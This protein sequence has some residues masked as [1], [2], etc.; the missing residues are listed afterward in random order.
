MSV[1]FV[2]P[3]RRLR[4]QW[5]LDPGDVRL[6]PRRRAALVLLLVICGY[7]ALA[8]VGVAFQ[9]RSP[10]DAFVSAGIVV[11]LV[12]L[13]VGYLSRP[14]RRPR[15]PWS[16]LALLAQAA[17][18]FLGVLAFGPVWYGF[19]GFLA[20]S[21]LIV[22]PKAVGIPVFALVLAAVVAVSV[23]SAALTDGAGWLVSATY[24]LT[25]NT[26]SALAVFGLSTLARLVIAAHDARAELSR[27][28]VARERLHIARDLHDL[29]GQGLSAIT[30]QC[31]L[32][33][34][35][36]GEHPDRA[37]RVLAD[38]IARARRAASDARTVVGLR[39]D[40]VP[41][42]GASHPGVPGAVAVTVDPVALRLPRI[43]LTVVLL[44]FPVSAAV[45]IASTR[46]LGTAL[47]ALVVG[48]S[49]V[50]LVVR[51]LARPSALHGRAPLWALALLVVLIYAPLP[52]FGLGWHGMPGILGGAVLL[53]LPGLAGLLGLLLVVASTL[54]VEYVDPPPTGSTP[55]SLLYVGIGAVVVSLIVYGLGRV[56]HLVAEVHG[57]RED[58]MRVAVAR[59][60]LRI[61]R[62]VHDLLGLS[63]STVTLKCELASRLL[64]VDPERARLEVADALAAARRALSDVRTVIGGAQRL[65]LE[66][67]CQLAE[68]TLTAADVRVRLR[69]SGAMPDEPVNSVL[70][71]VLREGVTNVLRHSEAERCEIELRSSRGEVTLDISNDG[72]VP[73]RS[74]AG[75]PPE[76]GNGLRNMTHRVQAIGGELTADVNGRCYRLRARV[77]IAP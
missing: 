75:P 17:L 20:G 35:L 32:L 38:V 71:T 63:L 6:P 70:A 10:V 64:D 16:L 57:A 30:L 55:E 26:T 74:Q 14:Q 77:P 76:Q 65:S 34:R 68:S 23:S 3:V 24:F 72:V 41:G 58:L 47:L 37:P 19:S 36:V 59:E 4:P 27:V 28:A 22:L 53:V 11:L 52:V 66:T 7:G 2:E 8:I 44:G 25:S 67:E 5:S 49:I 45:L 62:D 31:E 48:L 9:T 54:V 50:V 1:S 13:Q 18:V 61:A 39:H 15:P 40:L 51:Y 56:G 29:L 69:H 73:V 42:D 12:A 60:R 33:V 43:L 46:H 21:A